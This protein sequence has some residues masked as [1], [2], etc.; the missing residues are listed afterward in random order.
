MLVA[1]SVVI[2]ASVARRVEL[3]EVFG[4]AGIAIVLYFDSRCHASDGGKDGEGGS[5]MHLEQQVVGKYEI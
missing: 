1:I 5:K 2:T 3:D 4:A